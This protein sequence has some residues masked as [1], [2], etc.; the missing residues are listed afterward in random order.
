[1]GWLDD[2]T[3]GNGL[4]AVITAIVTVWLIAHLVL[5]SVGPDT[6]HDN[7]RSGPPTRGPGQ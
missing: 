6:L 7:D 5:H 2:Q 1:M 4:I 3:A